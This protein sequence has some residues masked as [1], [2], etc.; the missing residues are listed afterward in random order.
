MTKRDYY[1][2]LEVPK[3]ANSDEVKKAYRKL[4]LKYH[5]DRNKGDKES[6]ERFKEAAEAYEVLSDPEKRQLY[7]RF[8]HAGLQQTGFRGFRDFDDIFSSFGDIFEEF[9]GF[10]SRGGQRTHARRGADIRYEVSI[11]FMDAAKGMETEVD[12]SRH[13]RCDECGGLGTKDGAQ[14]SVCSTCGGRGTI[15]RSQGFFSISTTCPKCQGSGTVITDPCKKCRGVGR[16]LISKKLSLRIPAGVDTGSRLR[17]QGEGEPGDPGAPPGDLYV[18]IRVEPHQVFRRQDDDIL[19]AVPI[20][21]S[22]ATLGGDI[23]IPTLD[24]QDHME[25]PQGTQSGQDFR[26]SGK[27]IPHL[28][29]RGRGDLVVVVYI[30]T[31][32]KLNKEEEELIRRLAEIEGVK[33]TQKK[34]GFFSKNK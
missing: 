4:A 6:E 22:L 1:E 15:T 33:V 5:P 29:G 11:S 12:V 24:G 7:D 16:I 31:P 8:G 20:P 3:T 21:Y 2:V 28:R 10:G 32:K 27:G 34:R 9:F 26:L 14:P 17:L 25:I 13:E 18:F 30:Q 19:V 23:E